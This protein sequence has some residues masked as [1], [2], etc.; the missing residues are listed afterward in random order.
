[1]SR[2]FY[3]FT[4]SL[5]LATGWANALAQGTSTTTPAQRLQLDVVDYESDFD[6]DNEVNV[7]TN[8]LSFTMGNG[9]Q[10]V[11]A[12][13]L[14][15]G[16]NLIKIHRLGSDGSNTE[17]VRVNMNA[18]VTTPKTELI[19]VLDFYG[20]GSNK[21]SGTTTITSSTIGNF[22]NSTNWGTN[23]SNL[24]WQTSGYGY[25]SGQG[26][27]TYT[28]PAGYSNANFQF[29]FMVGSNARGGTFIYNVND[30]GWYIGDD[31]A[32]ANGEA[33]FILSL[34]S[35]DVVS[36]YGASGNSLYSSPD[37][38]ILGVFVFP[39]SYIPSIDVTPTIS[40]FNSDN[41]TWG[42][43][44]AMGSATTLTVNDEISLSGQVT[45]VFSVE[46][47]N[48]NSHPD[49]Y[50]YKADFNANVELPAAG[51]TGTSLNAGIDFSPLNNILV[52]GDGNWELMEGAGRYYTSSARTSTC[53]IMD[54][55]GSVLFT[56]PP[57]FMGNQ[58]SVT[59]T[60]CTGD[61][62][63]GAGVVYVNG[64]PYTF[65]A[66]ES[67]TW[68]V[69]TGANG[70]IEFRAASDHYSAGISTIVITS[71]NPS[72]LNAPANNNG[73]IFKKNPFGR[74]NSKAFEPKPFTDKAKV[75]VN[76]K[77]SINVNK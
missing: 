59:V 70:V 51:S 3:L 5:L 68:T 71:G 11:T 46:I 61:N 43:A 76:D 29:F 50:S 57:T 32:T 52:T 75:R 13:M 53:V 54:S 69:N 56:L 38:K 21:P 33:S 36:I 6:K 35:G 49:S 18:N 4:C 37:I 63:Y 66:G 23:G 62:D 74:D 10:K 2:F 19:D 48:D 24:I 45:D 39:D 8:T 67:H 27:L 31:S 55:W 14:N 65:T 1:M 20:D 17:V 22:T 58:L 72:S 64:I 34:S 7:Y 41:N 26:G 15:E 30:E 60:T 47:P 73:L 77:R 40:K 12:G 44:T 42:S 9:N 25:I 28:V 16:D